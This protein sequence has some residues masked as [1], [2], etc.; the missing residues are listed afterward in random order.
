[1]R[2][3]EFDYDLPEELIAQAPLARRDESRLFVVHRNTGKFEHVQFRDL[4]DYL[5]PGELTV[6]NDSKVIP[7]RLRGRNRKS[8]GQFELLL[9]E[10]VAPNDWWV[11]LRPGKRGHVGTE[12]VIND[13]I[14][15]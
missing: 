8:G 7:A 1:M 2:A 3:S 13:R 9:L 15:A 4:P 10:E 12:I 11:M 14:V 6:F 5:A